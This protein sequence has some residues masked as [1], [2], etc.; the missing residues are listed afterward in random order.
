MCITEV[1]WSR[2]HKLSHNKYHLHVN[3]EHLALKGEMPLLYTNIKTLVMG[4]LL[5]QH[6]TLHCQYLFFLAATTPELATELAL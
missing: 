2:H 3:W 1:S 6:N 5:F 4:K